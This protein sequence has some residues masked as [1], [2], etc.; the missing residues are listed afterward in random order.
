[1][2]PLSE[3]SPSDPF[4][5]LEALERLERLLEPRAGAQVSPDPIS[6]PGPRPTVGQASEAAL[7]ALDDLFA[8]GGPPP[9]PAAPTKGPGGAPLLVLAGC[10]GL[11]LAAATA[12]P[13]PLMASMKRKVPTPILRA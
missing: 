9:R 3:T 1:M 10:L 6:V 4:L 2:K 13:T 12:R 8:G 5:A 11:G 7:D